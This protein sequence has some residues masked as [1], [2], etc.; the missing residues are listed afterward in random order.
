[1]SERGVSVLVE[2]EDRRTR[3]A[4]G[5]QG[6]VGA[7]H[8]VAARQQRAAPRASVGLC[9]HGI[10]RY[11][12]AALDVAAVRFVTFARVAAHSSEIVRLPQRRLRCLRTPGR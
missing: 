9:A 10:A 1:M 5:E 7:A 2:A 6:A 12:F 3:V 8:G 4:D 11:A